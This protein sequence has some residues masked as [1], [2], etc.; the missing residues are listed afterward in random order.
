MSRSTWM[1]ESDERIP[2]ACLGVSDDECV[3]CLTERV[4][5]AVFERMRYTT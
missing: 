2:T 1:C 3:V 4:R 5:E